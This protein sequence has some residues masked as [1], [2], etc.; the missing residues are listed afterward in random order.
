MTWLFVL[1]CYAILVGF[2]KGT[3]WK[4]LSPIHYHYKE[5]T[6]FFK[7]FIYLRECV[8]ES[9]HKQREE[10]GGGEGM[11]EIGEASSPLITEPSS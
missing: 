7:D 4:H 8:C 6:I 10:R 11:W 1:F 2:Q 9:K 5:H 3:K